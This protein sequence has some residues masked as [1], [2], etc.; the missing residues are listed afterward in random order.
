MA[1]TGQDRYA[2][3]VLAKLRADLVLKDG[4]VFNNDYEGNPVAGAVKIPVR[5]TE[6]AVGDYST[7]N[8]L[9]PAEG[10]TTYKTVTIN[11]SK[12]INEI[13][14]GYAADSVPDN[15]VAERLDSGSYSLGYQLDQDGASV[16]LAGSTAQNA[17]SLDATNAYDEIVATRTAMS[18]ANVPNDGKRYILVT[19]DF[20][21][22][23]LKSDEFI[24][25][26]NLGDEVKQMGVIGRIA[27][28]N[29]IEWNDSTAN[30]QYIAGHPR[31]ATRINEWQVPVALKDLTNEYIG[32]SAV[33][34]RMVYA[35]DVARA[36]AIRACYSPGTLALT[37]AVGT[38]TAGD[39]KV[40]ATASGSNTLAYK[41]NPTSRI[42]YGTATATYAGTVM[43]SGTA[44]V[45]GSQVAGNIIEV[46]EFDETTG[47]CVKVGYV[48][49]TAADIK[50]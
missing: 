32:S 40:T 30:L 46:A 13:I 47:L 5:D 49:L 31:F 29:V 10:S 2:N 42:A 12:A 48:T 50:A 9:S 26:S 14:D 45:I 3:L 15:L 44:K 35:H 37:V 16:L 22:L 6:V 20:L 17:A 41:V 19:P 38:T 36:T 23:L 18:K 4:V 43:T 27:G 7:A 21:A 11:K 33:Q 39:T 24:S 28:F 25:A 8:G 34:G 1:H